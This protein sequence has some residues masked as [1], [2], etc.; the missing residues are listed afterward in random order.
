VWTSIDHV[1]GAWTTRSDEIVE[2]LGLALIGC[3]GFESLA[4]TI[5][6]HP[7]QAE[8]LRFRKLHDLA[9][10]TR[11]TSAFRGSVYI[12]VGLG[13]LI[14][15]HALYWDWLRVASGVTAVM[16]G[17]VLV[18]MFTLSRA[19][20]YAPTS[21]R[22]DAFALKLFGP[23]DVIGTVGI[24]GLSATLAVQLLSL[25]PTADVLRC[26]ALGFALVAVLSLL[27]KQRAPDIAHHLGAIREDYCLGR[28]D[29]LTAR[30]RADVILRGVDFRGALAEEVD[31]F[32]A[33]SET[34]GSKIAAIR[35][36]HREWNALPD[37]T[38]DGVT[39]VRAA[40]RRTIEQEQTALSSAV[41]TMKASAKVLGV[42]ATRLGV[43]AIL[44]GWDH[45]DL[46][47]YLHDTIA[48]RVTRLKQA[49]AAM[50][51]ELSASAPT[52]TPE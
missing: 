25:H 45:K 3:A 11:L 34:V 52:S 29:L 49:H 47:A 18:L 8:T 24:L 38:K 5:T 14:G 4:K 20:W 19:L 28:T 35:S 23:I 13:V 42:S 44:S 30:N 37:V 46:A 10:G 1:G 41:S 31:R 12:G 7:P 39:T 16:I 15:G 33:A 27:A 43:H 6:G 40:L 50:Q 51:A 26:A 9:A 48:E 2:W 36:M 17:L 32:A 22:A 21:V